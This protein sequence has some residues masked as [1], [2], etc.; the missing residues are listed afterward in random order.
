[1][2]WAVASLYSDFCE[3]A[4]MFV[5]S[6][7]DLNGELL[8]ASALTDFAAIGLPPLTVLDLPP[9]VQAHGCNRMGKYPGLGI[10][11]VSNSFK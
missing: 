9:C 6:C 4:L 5:L 1:M 2:F 10:L 11:G 3:R 7:T 8:L